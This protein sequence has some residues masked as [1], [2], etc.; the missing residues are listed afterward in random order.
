MDPF[1]QEECPSNPKEDGT[2]DKRTKY[3]L[4]IYRV[5]RFPN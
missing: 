2:S 1:A 3:D 4:A 5:S